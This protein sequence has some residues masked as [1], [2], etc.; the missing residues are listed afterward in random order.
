MKQKILQA[1]AEK[2]R[3]LINAHKTNVE[4]Q[5]ANLTGVAEHIDHLETI[6]KELEKM[7]HYRDLLDEVEH[8]MQVEQ[9]TLFN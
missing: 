5:C 7:A 8:M 6:E 4:I 9:L 3:A 1:L 2:Y